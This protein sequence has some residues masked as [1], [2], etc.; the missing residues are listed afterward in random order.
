MCF[1]PLPYPRSQEHLPALAHIIPSKLHT[2]EG[3]GGRGENTEDDGG[4]SSGES[5][6]ASGGNDRESVM[7]FEQHAAK[8]ASREVLCTQELPPQIQA[9]VQPMT[10]PMQA[11]ATA[12]VKEHSEVLSQ[13]AASAHTV[14]QQ[15][16][17]TALSSQ[18]LL[19]PLPPLHQD[20]EAVSMHQTEGTS[21]RLPDARHYDTS[22]V[23]RLQD[24]R[25]QDIGKQPSEKRV[26]FD[27]FV[28]ADL[29][30]S[31]PTPTCTYVCGFHLL[32]DLTAP[33]ALMELATAPTQVSKDYGVVL[34]MGALWV[35]DSDVCLGR[36]GV[37]AGIESQDPTAVPASNQTAA[38]SG[39]RAGDCA[40][41]SS[42]RH[43][44]YCTT[45]RFTAITP[46]AAH[47]ASQIAASMECATRH[48]AATG[49]QTATDNGV[50]LEL[51]QVTVMPA[52]GASSAHVSPRWPNGALDDP[53]L[54]F[55]TVDTASS[56]PPLTAQVY[57]L[58]LGNGED[59]GKPE[60]KDLSRDLN[61][62]DGG[63]KKCD[64]SLPSSLTSGRIP[65]E[66]I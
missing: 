36:T 18:R 7:K 2:H 57:C 20:E 41:T 24:T 6:E 13:P 63:S 1:T 60:D 26:L 15:V 25:L 51:K 49:R 56:S 21:S 22:H 14:V 8:H 65:W 54:V 28:E 64:L 9:E 47:A 46:F 40:S 3:E 12:T 34:G 39:I 30:A 44:M 4:A 43:L 42:A 32:P 50:A 55:H 23:T 58:Q 29:A 48:A 59:V 31:V 11:R 27:T 62:V 45:P 10:L 33:D 19:L 38:G 52:H 53:N 35:D 16:N 37:S 66:Q 5:E 17:N 61:E